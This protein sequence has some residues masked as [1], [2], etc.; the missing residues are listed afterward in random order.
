MEFP[1]GTTSNGSLIFGP[2]GL[3]IAESFAGSVH[4]HGLRIWP[5]E[6]RILD[7]FEST[8]E[9][10]SSLLKQIK[11]AAEFLWQRKVEGSEIVE[12]R[13]QP[14]LYP[15]NGYFFEHDDRMR[16]LLDPP[17]PGRTKFDQVYAWAVEQ[18]GGSR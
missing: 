2:D 1:V 13:R 9:K 3:T 7:L 14:R 11:L 4:F 17:G 15:K 5:L 16:P 18:A 12:K 10:Q 8:G 6:P